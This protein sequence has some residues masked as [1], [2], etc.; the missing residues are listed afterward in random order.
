MNKYEMNTDCSYGFNLKKALK[1]KK[2]KGQKT[3]DKKKVQLVSLLAVLLEVW[4]D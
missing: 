3:N 1:K 2:N 4:L